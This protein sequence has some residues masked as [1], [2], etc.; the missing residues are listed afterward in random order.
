[1]KTG[2]RMST[3]SIIGT[4]VIFCATL[5]AVYTLAVAQEDQTGTKHA[6]PRDAHIA[7][8]EEMYRTYCAVCHGIDGKGGAPATPALRDQV[9][10]LTTLSQSHGGKYPAQYVEDVLRFGTEKG[11][12][13]HGNKDMPIWGRVFASMPKSNKGTV[14]RRISDLNQYLGTLQAK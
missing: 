6:R 13:A 9:P 8:G 12:P 14:T 11:F 5:P 7:S 1:M 4:G 3:V 2:I 10:D